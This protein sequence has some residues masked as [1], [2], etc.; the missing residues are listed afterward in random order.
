MPSVLECLPAPERK[1]THYK[2]D[3]CRLT[4]RRSLCRGRFG[5]QIRDYLVVTSHYCMFRPYTKDVST[6]HISD[7]DELPVHRIFGSDHRT[8][9]TDLDTVIRPI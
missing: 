9:K 1:G 4:Y 2:R 7:I 5:A 3:L 8:V 6:I